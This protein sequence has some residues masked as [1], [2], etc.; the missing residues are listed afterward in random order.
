MALSKHGN[1]TLYSQIG[2]KNQADIAIGLIR[3]RSKVTPTTSNV[4][5]FRNMIPII[6]KSEFLQFLRNSVDKMNIFPL[7]NRL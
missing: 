6:H 2:R 5:I 7:E 3:L 4:S 1:S